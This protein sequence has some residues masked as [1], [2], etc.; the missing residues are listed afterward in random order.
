MNSSGQPATL[1]S[2]AA[3]LVRLIVRKS[4]GHQIERDPAKMA[5]WVR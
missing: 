5:V 1:G 2:T 4:C 3:A